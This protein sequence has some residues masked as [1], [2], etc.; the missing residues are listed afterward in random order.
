MYKVALVDDHSLLRNGLANLVDS[1]EGF[2]VLFE[3][4][5]GK[6][7]INKLDINNPP[8]VVLMDITMPEM[9]GFE[10]TKWIKEN[11]P[12][13]KVLALSMMDDDF[14]IIKMLKCGARGYALKNIKAKELL[15]SLTEIAEKGFFFNEEISNK[16][17]LSVYNPTEKTIEYNGLYTITPKE[18]EFLVH[19]C[20][21][22]SYKEI[23]EAMFISPRTIDTYRDSLFQKL[24]IKTRVGLVMYAIKT[25]LFKL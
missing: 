1:F 9:D 4:D 2:E 5:N 22:K 25:G 19:A 11:H 15:E 8:D 23:A 17:A 6:D 21:E 12:K 24:N 3:A 16:I 18:T 13:I 10:T 20:S 7:F 14:S